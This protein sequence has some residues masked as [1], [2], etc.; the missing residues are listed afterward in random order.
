MD[1]KIYIL[2]KYISRSLSEEEEKEFQ[3]YMLNDEDFRRKMIR[4]V[5]IDNS[6]DD[7]LNIEKISDNQSKTLPLFKKPGF[8]KCAMILVALLCI[9]IILYFMLRPVNYNKLYKSEYQVMVLKEMRNCSMESCTNVIIENYRNKNYAAV[10]AFIT[11][12]ENHAELDDLSILLAGISCIEEDDPVL[13]EKQFLKISP[14]SDCRA[15]ASWYL[16]LLNLKKNNIES[17][18]QYLN[19]AEKS[20]I[21]LERARL[22]REKILRK[23]K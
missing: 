9:G 18:L 10:Y 23:R 1:R 22:L 16:A 6:L 8:Y 21:Y 14:E 19:E 17:C 12:S 11:S 2:H 4:A 3:E 15:S 5:D 13:A 20:I 7:W